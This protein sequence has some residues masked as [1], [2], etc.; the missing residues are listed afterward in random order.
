MIDYSL[1]NSIP[2]DCGYDEWLK[3]GMALKHEGASCSVWDNWSRGGTKYKPG[4]CERKWRSF[5]RSDVTGGTLYA[6]GSTGM[7]QA[8]SSDSSVY[9]IE[10]GVTDT[11]GRIEVK[12]SDGN[13]V[14]SYTSDRSY[15]NLTV[16]SDAFQEG[17][18]YIVYQNGTELGSVTI[19]DLISYVN[20][21]VP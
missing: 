5:K 16:S 6:G 20:Y 14:A 12:D 10:I 17:E 18:T 8:P 9:T 4:E 15:G 21:P 1:L 11:S 7:V 2:P 3:V 13:T 19:S